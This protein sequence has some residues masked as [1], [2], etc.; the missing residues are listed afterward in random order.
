MSC[1]GALGIL[2]DRRQEPCGKC[3]CR[4]PA[5]CQAKV[6]DQ[7]L[8]T[9]STPPMRMGHVRRKTLREYLGRETRSTAAKTTNQQN[10]F[11]L[12]AMRR[13]INSPAMYTC[14]EHGVKPCRSADKPPQP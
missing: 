14:C 10:Q 1:V 7:P 2:V 13:K 6:P 12:P 5:E 4:A 11:H 3:L 8:Q 9:G